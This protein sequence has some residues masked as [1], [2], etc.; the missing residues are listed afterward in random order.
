VDCLGTIR[1]ATEGL[2]ATGGISWQDRRKKGEFAR[3]NHLS[4][5]C[6]T[7]RCSVPPDWLNGCGTQERKMDQL[8]I[9]NLLHVI[10]DV[11]NPYI[12]V[13]HA[14]SCGLTLQQVWCTSYEVTLVS[15]CF[16]ADL[17]RYVW[18]LPFSLVS[19]V[20]YSGLWRTQNIFR[21][22]YTAYHLSH[23]DD[24]GVW[25]Q[26]G[27]GLDIGFIDTCTHNSKIQ[28][29]IALSLIC[30]LY[31]SPQHPL[32]LLSKLLFLHQPFLSKG[33]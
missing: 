14:S 30:T 28:V 4:F 8:I 21:W 10:L 6:L 9:Q 25:L 5:W 17:L 3:T 23:C 11:L 31:T 1:R 20:W 16:T 33:S 32:N 7:K 12:T 24:L 29:I 27:Y 15:A 26:T 22:T 19:T 13:T 2:R 18:S